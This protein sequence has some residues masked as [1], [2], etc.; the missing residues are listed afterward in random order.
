MIRNS[1][2]LLM[3]SLLLWLGWRLGN[4]YLDRKREIIKLKWVFKIKRK[5]DTSI[6]SLKVRLV[7]MCCSQVKAK[8]YDKAFSSTLQI[9]TL[10]LIFTLLAGEG[11]VGRQPVSRPIFWTASRIGS[12]FLRSKL[13]DVRILLIRIGCMSWV[14]L[15]R[16]SRILLCQCNR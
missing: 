3:M 8:D 16:A 7:A 2:M 15:Y 9:E 11:W 12:S 5:V 14:G 1:W 4:W 6:L 13:Q 10:R